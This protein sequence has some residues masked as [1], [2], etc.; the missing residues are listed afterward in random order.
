MEELSKAINKKEVSDGDSDLQAV[1]TETLKNCTEQLKSAFDPVN[2]G[3][4][5]APKFPRPSEILALLAEYHRCQVHTF[6][7]LFS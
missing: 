1:I 7:C 4:S 3:F 6:P 5:Q 2:G